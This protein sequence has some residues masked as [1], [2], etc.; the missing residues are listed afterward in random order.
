MVLGGKKDVHLDGSP[1]GTVSWLEVIEGPRGRRVRSEAERAR[2]VAESLLLGAHVSEVARK[3][4]ATRWQIYYWRRRFRQRGA[5]PSRLVESFIGRY[6]AG[7]WDEVSK[8][9]IP[10]GAR[11]RI[12]EGG[13][14][15]RL[16]LS[17]ARKTDVSTLS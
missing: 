1:I 4:G 10:V 12:T 17:S 9:A 16:R 11:I 6:I 7:G 5:F 13:F 14:Q 8:G 3:H 15:M 2:I